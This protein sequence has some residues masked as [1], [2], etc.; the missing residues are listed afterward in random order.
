MLEQI[1]QV[2]LLNREH[3]VVEDLDT[4]LQYKTVQ[5]QI[6][7]TTL[8][9]RDTLVELE[10]LADLNHQVAEAA[11]PVVLVKMDWD[12]DT[13]EQQEVVLDWK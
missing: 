6:Q 9:D 5:P 8:I 4:Q 7:I 10:H 13:L 12:Q 11:V 1:N 2:M 3:L